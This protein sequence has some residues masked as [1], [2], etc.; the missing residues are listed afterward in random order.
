MSESARI[1]ERTLYPYIGKIFEQLG[2]RWYQETTVSKE[3]PDLVLEIDGLKLLCGV[4]INTEAKLLDDLS[5]AYRKALALRTPNFGTILF[6]KYIRDVPPSELDRTYPNIEVRAVFLTEWISDE[7]RAISLRELAEYL[8][9]SYQEY[10]KLKVPKVSYEL[11]VKIARESIRELASLL[12]RFFKIPELRQSALAVIGRFDIFRV[13]L[14]EFREG[15]AEEGK[16][17]IE[18][19]AADLAAYLLINQLLFYHILSRKLGL[20]EFPS[21]NPL[22]PPEDLLDKIS[23]FLYEVRGKYP[24]ILGPA[25]ISVFQKIANQAKFP[26]AKLISVLTSLHPEHISEDL[27]GRLYHETIPEETRKAL[28]AFYTKPRAARL[29]AHLA[30]DRWDAKVL[31]PAC[32]SGTILVE[33]YNRKKRLAPPTKPDELHAKLISQLYGIDI[34]TFAFHMS[35]INLAAQNMLVP[36]DPNV[37]PRDGISAM[38]E[39]KPKGNPQTPLLVWIEG[40]RKKGIPGDFDVI[41]MNPP[42]TRRERLPEQ[43]RRRVKKLIPEVKGRVG[44]WAYFV[45]A[46]DTVLKEG[47]RLA[48]VAPEGFFNW[49]GE[50]VRRYLV[51]RGYA[52]EF[53]VKSAVEF[54]SE[55]A[56]FRDYLVIMRKGAPKFDPVVVVLKKRLDELDVDELAEEMLDFKAS[57]MTRIETGDF[58][59]LKR[60]DELVSNYIKNLKP[61]VGLN[62]LEGFELFS[63]LMDEIKNLPKLSDLGLDIFQYNPG[64]YRG[65]KMVAEYARK[66]F[67]SRYG[68]RA[69][70]LVFELEVSK[71]RIFFVERRNRLKFE[72]RRTQVVPSLRSYAGVNHMD[73]TGEEEFAIVDPSVIP[74]EVRRLTG[75]I[76]RALLRKAAQDIA[77]AYKDHAGNMLL[78]RRV[79]LTT[80]PYIAYYSDNK[81]TG[82]AVLLNVRAKMPVEHMKALTLYLNSSI[83]LIQLLALLSETRG[84][85]VDIHEKPMWALVRVPDIEHLS[86]D[87]IREAEQIFREVG[88]RDAEPMLDRLR[89]SDYIQVK[90]DEIA[91]KMAGLEHWKHRIAELHKVLASEVQALAEITVR[92][93]RT[94]A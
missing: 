4:K 34:M 41:V 12:R 3:Y 19:Y 56:A 63:E 61:L 81:L 51:D 65:N 58:L 39:A 76:N 8:T 78:G 47:G 37:I 42:F 25:L 53:V 49:A 22:D 14:E 13:M 82:T 86:T 59:A 50:S 77:E 88:K 68:A 28:G 55:Q 24:R 46:A 16:R 38:L 64:F 44:Y 93:S 36:C 35:C 31:D 91:L 75:L 62:T 85:W 48:L 90:I 52:I 45:V 72:V 6:P 60:P 26:I 67:A 21:V 89:T 33:C 70:S 15:Q 9:R 79:F 18:L 32:G 27:L 94:R 73:I 20:K 30:I 54:F 17:P 57:R 74:Q 1:T 69:P 5:D 71:K 87:L 10:L 7:L 40:L 43:E 80:I 29:L 11:V 83:T 66:L 84:A 2:W 23:E 92:T